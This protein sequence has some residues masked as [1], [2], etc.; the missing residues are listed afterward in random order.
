[1]TP[2]NATPDILGEPGL[3]DALRAANFTGN[4][5]QVERLFLITERSSQLDNLTVEKRSKIMASIKW[6]DTRPEMFV[7]RSLHALGFRFRLHD[8]RFPGRPDLVLPR[9]HVA[10]LIHGCF[11]HG[12]NCSNFRRS[13]TRAEWWA[14]K[15]ES[16]KTR[17]CRVENE[18][19]K[20]GWRVV[21]IWE[22]Q[23]KRPELLGDLSS[24]IKAAE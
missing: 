7:R 18:L 19:R 13:T 22:C 14:K 9:Y 11:W 16:N 3:D 15:I 24:W 23:L 8:R 6:R 21:V 17:D 12:H 5:V 2:R 1:M 20:L 4:I 10:I